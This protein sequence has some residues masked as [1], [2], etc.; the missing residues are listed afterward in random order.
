MM[1]V[2]PLREFFE[3]AFLTYV[4][5][6]QTKKIVKK[7]ITCNGRQ[8]RI[9]L[10]TILA[11]YLFVNINNS[12]MI[13]RRIRRWN[14]YRIGDGVAMYPGSPSCKAFPGSIVCAYQNETDIPNNV[15][16]LVSVLDKRSKTIAGEGVAFVH[17]RL[18]DGLC[19]KNEDPCRSTKSGDPD[20]W[21]D[22]Q[23]CWNDGMQY[24]YSKH[25]YNSVISQLQTLHIKRINIV[26]DKF[27]WTRMTDPRLGDFSVDEAYLD[28]MAHFF[29][30]HGFRVVLHDLGFPDSDFIY[31]CSARV[32]VRGGGGYSMLVAQVVKARG[33]IV[34]EPS[35]H[36]GKIAPSRCRRPCH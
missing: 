32:F 3:K 1:L 11:A 30:S 34:I 17:I 21:N 29:R 28:R 19:A 9:I 31:L 13:R 20:C 16:V 18:G 8:F 15:S 5:G 12:F 33:G 10:L 22:D 23:D 27:H 14:Q 36:L 26:G 24:A 6:C 35:T 7:N 4:N 2:S 25:W